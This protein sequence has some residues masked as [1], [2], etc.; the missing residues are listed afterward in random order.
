MIMPEQQVRVFS[1]PTIPA[2]GAAIIANEYFKWETLATQ[3]YQANRE[4]WDAIAIGFTPGTAAARDIRLLFNPA[5][6]GAYG[7]WFG[8]DPAPRNEI[9]FVDNPT[10]SVSSG[11]ANVTLRLTNGATTIT[12]VTVNVPMGWSYDGV[13]AD[14]T[15]ATRTWDVDYSLN[16]G[17]YTENPPAGMTV[18]NWSA[19]RQETIA[20]G[21]TLTL[22]G[23]DFRTVA[24]HE[25]GHSIG[26]G[27]PLDAGG[28]NRSGPGAGPAGNIMAWDVGNQAVFNRTMGIDNNSALAAAI[29]Y[30]WSYL[31]NQVKDFGDAPDSYKT[32]LSSD[33][34]RY[35]D[36]SA[37]RLGAAW[38]N[39][40]DGQPTVQAIG[41]DINYWGVG[42]TDDEDG[43]VFGPSGVDVTITVL[44]AGDML[45]RAWWD[46]NWNGMFDHTSELAIDDM[47][48]T[49][50]PGVYV[51]H[52]NLG[53]DPRN[54]YSRFRLTWA[55]EGHFSA[56]G[57]VTPWGEFLD[58]VTSTSHGEVEDYVPEPGTFVL[59]AIGSVVSLGF[60]RSRRK[61]T[62]GRM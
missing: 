3:Q 7:Q 23:M 56:I 48:G 55:V 39:E 25:I 1:D 53:F 21:D 28:G 2:R 61:N 19:A 45:L 13:F 9:E 36:G 51:K 10:L 37:A 24:T 14:G 43:V 60:W 52:Y 16:G 34:P 50:A 32:L 42:V 11:F 30:T 46:L 26:L 49:L 17:A 33:G 57:D 5:L 22:P 4:P 54:Y 44:A 58:E 47:L 6:G 29:D 38:D 27:H 18:L 35:A 12:G 62:S 20:A 15:P 41:D 8:R 31:Q 40:P 59:L